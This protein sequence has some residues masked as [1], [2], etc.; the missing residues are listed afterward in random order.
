RFTRNTWIQR[1]V[2]A[3]EPLPFADKSIDF[4][5]CSHTLE[6]IRDPIGLCGEIVR[7]GKAGYVE[8]P[9]RLEEQSYGFQGPWA[10]WGHHHWLVEL[11]DGGLQFVFKH[12]VMHGR[13]SD[14]FPAG[15]QQMLNDEERVVTLFWEG[16]FRFWEKIFESAEGLDPYLA[17]FVA[18]EL[19]RRPHF[20]APA[21][22]SPLRP[23]RRLL[24]RGLSRSSSR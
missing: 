17:D 18:A 16:S 5:V 15:F 2:C 24:R 10:G 22:G 9:S 6:D 7:V 21:V 14:H 3:R 12:H 13:A 19:A 20:R 11:Q 1:D 4:V 8:T 23:L